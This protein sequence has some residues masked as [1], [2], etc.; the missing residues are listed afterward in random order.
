MFD[1]FLEV[2]CF[3]L[4]NPAF[5]DADVWPT[6]VIRVALEEADAET[7][8]SRW[9]IYK[10]DHKNKKRRGVF[11]YAAHWLKSYYPNGAANEESQTVTGS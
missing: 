5:K 9:G 8:G 4:A 10:D 11:L 6:E 2:G 1:P 3:R 7:S